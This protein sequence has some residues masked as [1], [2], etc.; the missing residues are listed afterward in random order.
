MQIKATLR[1]HLTPVR[2]AKIKN[3]GE[4][5]EVTLR[6]GVRG[7]GQGDERKG[8]TSAERERRGEEENRAMGR[9]ADVEKAREG[10]SEGERGRG[11][12]LFYFLNF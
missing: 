1:F 4:A 5:R 6:K 8:R 7:W 9:G 12:G 3:S 2:M 11:R 10:G